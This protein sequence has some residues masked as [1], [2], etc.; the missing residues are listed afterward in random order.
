MFDL[1]INRRDFLI[2]AS[3]VAVLASVAPAIVRAESIMP[4]YVPPEPRIITAPDEYN[5]LVSGLSGPCQVMVKNWETGEILLHEHAVGSVLKSN[6]PDNMGGTPLIV[7]ARHPDG[8]NYVNRVGAPY[9]GG[10]T[11]IRGLQLM[12]ESV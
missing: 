1:K 4:I 7:Y 8:K 10:K 11:K 3:K 9:P 6:V 12:K 2:G 5:F